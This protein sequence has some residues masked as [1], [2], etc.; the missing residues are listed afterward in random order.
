MIV[1]TI[2]EN[3]GRIWAKIRGL[4]KDWDDPLTLAGIKMGVSAQKAIDVMKNSGLEILSHQRFMFGFNNLII[5]KKNISS[6]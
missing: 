2:S 6:F 4:N 1:T 3:V 5:A